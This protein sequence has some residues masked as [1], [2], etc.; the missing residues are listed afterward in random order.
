[1]ARRAANPS[2][3]AGR[4]FTLVEILIVVVILGIL[5]AI[6]VSQFLGLTEEARRAAFATEVNDYAD[7]AILYMVD[8]GEFLEDSAS[9]D[10]PAGFEGYIDEAGWLNGTPI[11]GVWDF[12]FDSFGITS[13]FGVHFD[14][15]G[16]TQDDAF[17]ALVD[18]VLDDA[19]LETGGFIQIADDRYYEVLEF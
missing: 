3:G 17:M 15:T 16:D 6:V 7:A 13:A 14:G 2:V 19:D 11:G 4:G 8:T 9:G 18:G 5:A 10:V 12:E 1:M